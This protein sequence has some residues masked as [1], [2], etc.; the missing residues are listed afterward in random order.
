MNS[1]TDISPMKRSFSGKSFF[2]ATLC[3][4]VAFLGGLTPNASA[5]EVLESARSIPIA[6]DVD[7][8]VVGG[9]SGGVAA[10]VEAAK[11]GA[12]VFL[13]APRSFLGEDMCGTYRLFMEPGEKP[14]SDLAKA[15][16]LTA[17]TSL[18]GS[19]PFTYTTD[20][21]AWA[22]HAD[23]TPPS[24][25]ADKKWG[26]ATSDSV[27]FNQDANITI[28][29]GKSQGVQKL[30]LL[31]YQRAADFEVGK[32]TLSSSD[33]GKTWTPR[34]SFNNPQLG[35]ENAEST[36]MDL[37][38]PLAVT[39]RYLKLQIQKSA[40]AKRILIGE[41]VVE[42]D[43][44][45]QQ[46]AAETTQAQVVT[47]LQVKRELDSALIKAKVQ[48]LFGC[49][50]TDLLVDANGRPAGIV[51][52]NRSGRQAVTA[53]VIIDATD[54]G[55][56][57]RLAR[58]EFAP[59]PSGSQPFLRNVVGG[60]VKKS[61]NLSASSRAKPFTVI[62]N[63]GKTHEVI[64]YTA[65]VP[66]KDASFASFA[67]AEQLVRDWTW[68][69]EQVDASELPF[70]L[71]PD[72]MRGKAQHSGAWTGVE[73]FPL[74]ALRPAK[75]DGL[76]VL[77]GC[78]DISREAAAV[79]VRPV[80]FIEVGTRVG[81]A[82]ADQAKATGKLT[83]V[84][85]A[86]SDGGEIV[87]QYGDV[88]EVPVESNARHAKARTVPSEKRT[89]PVIGEYDVV[90]VGGGTG[91]APAAIAAG[92]KGAKVLLVE[93]L[94]SLG[95]VGTT[96]FISTYYHGNRVGFTSE[97]DDGVK[98]FS[99]EDNNMK[100]GAW[101]PDMKAEWYRQECRKAGVDMWFGTLGAGAYVEGGSVR[102]VVIATTHGRGVVLAKVVV[103]STGNAD[104]AA[105]AGAPCTYT[106]DSEVAVQG[107]GLPPRNLNGRYLNTDYTYVDETDIFDIWRAF[108]MGREKYKKAYDLGQL[109][110]TR[111]RRRIIGDVE[112]SPLDGFLEHT[113]PD[114]V[115]LAKSNFDTHGYT[116]HPLFMLRPPDKKDYY[117]AMPYRA[118]L[119]RGLDGIIV[120]GL[121]VSAQRDTLPFIRMQPD[122]QNQGYAAGTAAAM[123]AK[124]G[125]ST[126]ALDVK[127]LQKHLVEKGNLPD[128]VLTDKDSF[129]LPKE[130]FTAAIESLAKDYQG[131]EVLLTQPE[132][133]KPLLRDAF[134]K[135]TDPKT[136]ITYAHILGILGDSAGTDVL[137][138]E[139]TAITKWDDGWKFKAMG[140]FGA[141]VSPLDSLI[142]AL[143]RTGDRRATPAILAKAKLLTPNSEFSHFRAVTLAL[144]SLNDPASSATLVELLNK[145]GMS[146]HALTTI[147][148]AI[149]DIPVSGT[150][151]TTRQRELIELGLARVLYRV[152][153]VDGLGA[154]LLRQY[155]KDIR[156]HYARHAQAVLAKAAAK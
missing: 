90:V 47:P 49:F 13:A 46:A 84:R 98:A 64:E 11:S 100:K 140:Q 60:P 81:R 18:P 50:P 147:D 120:T 127:A 102:G 145:P 28:D 21:K 103:D 8:V 77:G 43:A 63:R 110:D 86:H 153:D 71:P 151:T 30:H 152:G 42:G 5:K 118:L 9:S 2:F 53:K 121:G 130:R 61:E 119:P 115:V 25:L 129:P 12:K 73:K 69:Q 78:A 82:A 125:T 155:T 148:N 68:T 144:E 20:V 1:V 139:V 132:V 34:G 143:G 135:A 6:F 65:R 149:E 33:D 70:Q 35:G 26:E 59:Y 111:E 83:N 54:R 99:P 3:I 74:D 19:L 122:I 44:A 131:L 124:T 24:R 116:V 51:M 62:D 128:T 105:A 4:A 96:G 154:K 107:T 138:K 85:V 56:V 45:T 109:I 58:A 14:A 55:T 29:L 16:T 156:G 66:M 52:A 133:A 89:V 57:A 92:R 146:G 37:P 117:L 108:V 93:Y 76:F 72:A 27:Q 38:F 95:G 134:A 39:A 91:G 123:I 17:E 22:G 87:S 79:L 97:I 31:A 80:N 67:N 114:T 112:L 41:I 36:A 94:Y 142:I 32:V 48:F 88:R 7:V 126:R 150:D 106:G 113:W 10:A 40:E 15:L 104:V 23:T 75:V 101:I 137:I 141:S 136:K